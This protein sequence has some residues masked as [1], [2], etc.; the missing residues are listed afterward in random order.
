MSHRLRA[1]TRS[2]RGRCFL[3][4]NSKGGISSIRHPRHFRIFA[5]LYRGIA[6]SP[7]RVSTGQGYAVLTRTKLIDYWIWSTWMCFD[8]YEQ[9]SVHARKGDKVVRFAS[10]AWAALKQKRWI[11]AP[12]QSDLVLPARANEPPETLPS[13]AEAEPFVEFVLRLLNAIDSAG[14]LAIAGQ[15]D[16]RT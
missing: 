10:E 4:S 8:T 16:D 3:F 7:A 14:L 1:Q 5:A 13:R 9:A 11:A 2:A 6:G 15:R 12:Q